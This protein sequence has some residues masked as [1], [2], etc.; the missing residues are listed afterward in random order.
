M[1][2][3]PSCNGY[4]LVGGRS[5]RF[6]T[7]KALHELNGRPVVARP[8]EALDAACE[9]VELVAKEPGTYAHLGRTVRRDR[10]AHRS[11]LAG[12]A[13][14]LE[15]SNRPWNFVLACDLPA[16]NVSV[17]RRL[18]RSLVDGTSESNSPEAVI[19]V[20]DHGLQ[21]LS[22]LYA[23]SCRT[24][25]EPVI[26]RNGSMKRWLEERTTRR[27]RFSDGRPF[28]NVNRRTDLPSV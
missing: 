13:T 17:L 9:R 3:P 24:S 19:P 5:R 21:P 14:A 10:T 11:P 2:E 23:R 26:E 4:V 25:I 27:I 22:A 12:V 28:H 8:I 18:L 6:G 1:T 7:D 20:T 15:A 16:M